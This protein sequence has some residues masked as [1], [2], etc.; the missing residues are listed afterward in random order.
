MVIIGLK[1][2]K[3]CLCK[4]EALSLLKNTNTKYLPVCAQKYGMMYHVDELSAVVTHI[5][6]LKTH[7][8]LITLLTLCELCEDLQCAENGHGISM[9][10]Y[11]K[12][13]GDEMNW[14]NT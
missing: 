13:Y 5:I 12:L 2:S 7:S 3:Y 1:M 8:E 10:L 11:S 6:V 14:W 9:S 4:L